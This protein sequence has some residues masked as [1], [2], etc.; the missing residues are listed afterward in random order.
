MTNRV[1]LIHIALVTLVAL[2]LLNVLIGLINAFTALL[3]HDFSQRRIDIFR[4]SLRVAAHEKMGALGVEPSPNLSGMVLHL[5]LGS[6][7]EPVFPFRSS[8][9]SLLQIGAERRHSRPGTN[10][11]DWSVRIVRQMKVF[12]YAGEHGHWHLISTFREKR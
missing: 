10:H 6:K 12:C 1:P 7:E 2:E 3:L 11:D 5:M 4:H 9:F 8:G